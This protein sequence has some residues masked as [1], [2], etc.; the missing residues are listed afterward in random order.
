MNTAEKTEAV[1]QYVRQNPSENPDEG[2]YYMINIKKSEKNNFYD[3]E[4]GHFNIWFVN[5]IRKNEIECYCIGNS[6]NDFL[7]K[8]TEEMIDYLYDYITNK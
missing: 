6:E 2:G 5:L 3:K 8:P 7:M 1:A 4:H